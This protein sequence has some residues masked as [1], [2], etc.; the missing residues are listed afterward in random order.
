MSQTV[1]TQDN[2][3]VMNPYQIRDATGLSLNSVYAMLERGDLPGRKV[4]GRWLTR[5]ETFERWLDG[6]EVDPAKKFLKTLKAADPEGSTAQH[7]R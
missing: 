2:R 4:G 1:T 5:R 3:E 7:T 6:E